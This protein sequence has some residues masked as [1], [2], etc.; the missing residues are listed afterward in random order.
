HKANPPLVPSSFSLSVSFFIHRSSAPSHAFTLNSIMMADPSEG[1]GGGVMRDYRKGNW[2]ITETMTLIEGKKIN[3]DQRMK[4]ING[5]GRGNSTTTTTPTTSATK[6]GGQL[7]WKW[8][9]DYCWSKGCFRSQNQCNDKWDNLMRDYK[10]LRDHHRH[11]SA[12]GGNNKSYWEMDRVERRERNLPSNM[13]LQIY[14][15]LVDVVERP[16]GGGGGEYLRLMA[17]PGSGGGGSS[18]SGVGGINTSVSKVN[19]A[20]MEISTAIVQRDHKPPSAAAS[21]G[22]VMT[23]PSLL[24]HNHHPPTP[25]IMPLPPPPLQSPPPHLHPPPLQSPPPP[26]HPPPSPPLVT[27]SHDHY[28]IPTVD[29]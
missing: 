5:G 17:G 15:A 19:Q 23:P 14:D 8:V 25:V 22:V 6:A 7:R 3:D 4:R 21:A 11:V 9:E 24:L 10:K 2:T 27:Q 29:V 18:S 12:G 28:P 20:P 16:G 13:L 1:G 26:L